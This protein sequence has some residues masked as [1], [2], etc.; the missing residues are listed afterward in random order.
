[1]SLMRRWL[2]FAGILF[3]VI[4]LDQITKRVVVDALAIGESRQLIPFL[5]PFF[6]ITRG[7]NRGAAFGFLPQAGDLFMV[8]AVIIV[9]GMLIFYPRQPAHAHLTRIAFAL[10][11]AGAIGNALDRLQYGAVVDFIHYTIPGVI[12]NVSNIADHAIVLGVIL[13]LIDS[14]L[15]ERRER[16]A[17]NSEVPAS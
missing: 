9:V 2:L 14:F 13:L 4:I 7:E 1:M 3:P 12:S 10:V 17:H 11:C 16:A 15:T 8:F 5:F 6:Q